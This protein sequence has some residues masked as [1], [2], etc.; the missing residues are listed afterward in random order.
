MKTQ[1][2]SRMAERRGRTRETWVICADC[3]YPTARVVCL[4]GEHGVR[5]GNAVVC[6]S[7]SSAERQQAVGDGAADVSPGNGRGIASA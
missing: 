7:C 4:I 1:D 5:L 2:A 3:G 6:L